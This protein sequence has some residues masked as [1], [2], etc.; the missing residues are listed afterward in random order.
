MIRQMLGEVTDSELK[1]IIKSN[2]DR[3]FTGNDLE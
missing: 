1:E 3:G 2:F